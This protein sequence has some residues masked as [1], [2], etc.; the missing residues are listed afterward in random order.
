MNP[1]APLQQAFASTRQ[2]MDAVQ[3]DQMSAQSPCPEWDV[4]GVI[5]HVIGGMQFF[6]AGMK[7]TQ[8]AEGQNWAEGDYMAAFDQAAAECVDCFE[9]EGALEATVALPFGEMPGSAVMGIA[10]ADVF[11]HGWDIAKATGQDTN[12][13]P[14]L[15]AGI[16]AQSQHAIS[17]EW[18]G[19][20]ESPAPFGAEQHCADG[21]CSADQLAAF[22]GRQV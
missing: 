5:N 10:M 13:A 20:E 19:P 9:Q 21:S 18:R 14:E 16:L 17:P 2:V 4:A 1:T 15:A 7:G 3:A 12:L 8:P 22:L 6:T 11:T